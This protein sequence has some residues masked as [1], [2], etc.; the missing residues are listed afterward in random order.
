MKTLISLIMILALG[1]FVPVAFGESN[2]CG[3][4]NQQMVIKGYQQLTVSTV[5]LALTLPAGPIRKAIVNVEANPIRYRED[6]T[7]PTAS[8]GMLVIASATVAPFITICGPSVGQFRVIRQGAADAILNVT[9][10]GD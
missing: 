7:A 9:Y 6:G 8:I 4:E 10:I 2:I 3:A 5:A 1:L